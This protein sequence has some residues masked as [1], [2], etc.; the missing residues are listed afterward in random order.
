MN[1]IPKRTGGVL[2]MIVSAL[3]LLSGVAAVIGLWVVKGQVHDLTAGALSP[4][5]LALDTAGAALER[6]NTHLSNARTRVSDAQQAVGQWGQGPVGNGAVVAAISNT[7]VANLGAEI[8]Q[9]NKSSISNTLNLANSVNK[10]IVAVNKFPSV[11][12]PTLT[13]RLQTAEAR[14]ETVQDRMREL[15]TNL[16]ANVQGRLQVRASQVNAVLANI[17]SGLQSVQAAVDNYTQNLA[18]VQTQTATLNSNISRWI[19]IGGFIATIFLLWIVIS[20]V[21]MFLYGRSLAASKP[22]T[23]PCLPL[24]PRRP[25]RT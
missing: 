18:Q 25:E 1:S 4:V 10:T 2:I 8:D 15:S 22:K 11:N 23:P 16:Q 17:D 12:L 21:A 7:V 14:M 19:D 24:P 9:A 6:A 5:D 13:D 3:V 20:Q